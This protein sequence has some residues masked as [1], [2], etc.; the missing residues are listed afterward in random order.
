MTLD[1]YDFDVGQPR[2]FPAGNYYQQI[3]STTGATELDI[4]RLLRRCWVMFK[5]KNIGDW[6]S[7][8]EAFGRWLLAKPPTDDSDLNS[9]IRQKW[10]LRV[11]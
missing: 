10:Q 3:A 11:H 2:H 6:D 5:H 7:E 4:M 1:C 8:E 9:L